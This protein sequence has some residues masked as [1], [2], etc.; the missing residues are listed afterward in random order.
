[1]KRL[2]AVLLLVVLVTPALAE[3]PADQS[4]SWNNLTKEAVQEI[5]QWVKEAK[6]FAQEQA[7][8]VV[9]ELIRRDTLRAVGASALSL[10]LVLLALDQT[11][12]GCKWAKEN[13]NDFD[14]AQSGG[15]IVGSIVVGGFAI[16]GLV[17]A[18]DWFIC[19]TLAPR[20]YVLEQLA[21]FVK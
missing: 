15:R 2:L 18:I 10:V 19:V 11:R 16:I 1:M 17:F 13:C 12:R 5:L 3:Q 7:P 14:S 4:V 6:N 21:I 20:L 8:L 9:A